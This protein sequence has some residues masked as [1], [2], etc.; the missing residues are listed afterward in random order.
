MKLSPSNTFR[1]CRRF[2]PAMNGRNLQAK[3][4]LLQLHAESPSSTR[5]T[6]APGMASF[7]RAFS[8]I[9]VTQGKN[10]YVSTN[11]NLG[12]NMK[13]IFPVFARV[14]GHAANHALLVQQLVLERRNRAHVNSAE[15]Q[16]AAFLEGL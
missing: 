12:G 11:G 1:N 13:K 14:V 4:R 10:P 8:A 6:A 7:L 9:G 15:H 5:S 3:S 16:H 2:P